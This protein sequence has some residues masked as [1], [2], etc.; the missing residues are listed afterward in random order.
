LHEFT[1]GRRKVLVATDVAARGLHIADI[2]IVLHYDP[3]A[4]NKS[5]L[6]RSGRTAR[7]GGTGTAVTLVL[8]DQMEAVKRIQ[9]Q[10]RIDE[11]II[12]VFSNDPLLDDL[13]PAVIPA[14][15]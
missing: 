9:R 8:W 12:E 3:P 11:P 15:G 2:D 10:L 5:Y 14:A 4:D 7:A 6:H 13:A 1:V